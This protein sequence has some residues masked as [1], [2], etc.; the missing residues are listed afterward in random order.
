[1]GTNECSQPASKSSWD[2][3]DFGDVNMVLKMAH[4][5]K[6][7]RPHWV[8]R[9]PL[10]SGL[11][12]LTHW[13]RV[14]YICVGKPTTIGSNN[15]LSHGWHQSIIWINAAILFIEPL[16]TNFS[17]I[18]IEI[19]TVSF[20]KMRLRGSSAKWWP[21]CPGFNV[22]IHPDATHF[23]LVWSRWRRPRRWWFDFFIWLS[24]LLALCAGNSPVTGEF[25][26]QR[27]VTRSFDVFVDLRMNK[28]LSKQSWGWWFE[29]P[30]RTLWWHCKVCPYFDMILVYN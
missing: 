9:L 3:Q 29:T 1:M 18:L 13:G 11:N 12:V 16:G 4:F 28:R 15:G 6:F 20:R 10:Y 14:P 27:P 7:S 19:L 22:L 21:F 25:P 24:A 26:L 23:L 8:K 2:S 5:H 17:E 30:S